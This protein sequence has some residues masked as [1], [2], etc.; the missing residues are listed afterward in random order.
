MDAAARAVRAGRGEGL[1]QAGAEL[2][3]G[4][5]HQAERGHLGHLV[6]GAVPGQRLG[7]PPQHE[8]AVGLQHHIDEVDDDDPADIAQPQ[9]AHRLL[10]G[11]EIV[12]GHRLL[13]V[14]AG[15]GEL[16][17]V[18]V[19]DGHRL[20]AVDDQGATR[21]QPHL[22]VHRLGQLFVDAVHG[23]HVGAVRS[24]RLVFRQA[25]NKLRRNVIHVVADGVPGVVA[26]HDETGEVLVEQIA[27]HLDQYVGLFV[28]R[29]RGAGLL[30]GDLGGVG[31]D[32]CPAL[33]QP[34]HIRADVVFLDALGRG[35]DDHA[36]TGR[37]NLAQDLLEALPFGV[38]QL[39]ADSGRGRTRHVHEVAAGQ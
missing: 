5:L 26:G 30:L 33:L 27:D 23:E 24:T 22:A 36:G 20:G 13:E 1:D 19:D 9:L 18:D 32:L 21:G 3:A 4:Q 37:N 34:V 2:L 11:F 31:L 8:V 10:G 25:R 28:E 38:G 16:A 39:A 7:Q 14:A 12:L 6:T 17:G 15:T 29:D 35:P